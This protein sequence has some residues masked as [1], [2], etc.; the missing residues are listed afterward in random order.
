MT[1]L[2]TL[3]DARA[4]AINDKGQVV[5]SSTTAE[6]TSYAFLWENGTMRDLGTRWWYLQHCR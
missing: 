1:A 6:G 3:G 4:Y 5:G 2:G